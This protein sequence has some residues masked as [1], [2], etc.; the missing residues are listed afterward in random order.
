V[1]PKWRLWQLRLICI[2]NFQTELNCVLHP[3]TLLYYLMFVKFYHHSWCSCCFLV[4]NGFCVCAF[5]VLFIAQQCCF[6]VQVKS[7]CEERLTLVRNASTEAGCE[8]GLANQ[9]TVSNYETAG[10]ELVAS[11]D[12]SDCITTKFCEV[13]LLT[14]I[15][16]FLLIT[17]PY[18]D[19]KRL[20]FIAISI[21][22]VFDIRHFCPWLSFMMHRSFGN[23]L[24]C[25]L[26][27]CLL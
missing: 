8:N 11:D 20:V 7:I 15:N 27:Y 18:F 25:R 12:Q 10:V 17:N 19:W 21:Y 23:A 2:I 14:I 6:Y 3:Y 5:H 26:L 9:Q 22:Y 16:C 24:L 1:P 13:S 4:D